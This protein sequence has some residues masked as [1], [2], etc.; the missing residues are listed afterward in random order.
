M[1]LKTNACK[2]DT[3]AFS[4]SLSVSHTLAVLRVLFICVM[5]GHGQPDEAWATEEWKGDNLMYIVYVFIFYY[6]LG[7]VSP[8]HT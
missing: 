4:L 2:H 3:W 7:R 5:Y 8:V 1:R 6:R